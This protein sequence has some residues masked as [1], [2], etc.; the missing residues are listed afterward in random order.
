MLIGH[1]RGTRIPQTEIG[2]L[3]STVAQIR[4]A[5]WLVESLDFEVVGDLVGLFRVVQ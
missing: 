5:G 2:G 4:K 1:S 3:A